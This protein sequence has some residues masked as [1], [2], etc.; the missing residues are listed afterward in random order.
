MRRWLSFTQAVDSPNWTF[1]IVTALLSVFLF[2]VL[3]KAWMRGAFDLTYWPLADGKLTEQFATQPTL[4]NDADNKLLVQQQ[5][6]FYPML[7]HVA[8]L[9]SPVFIP[10]LLVFV[11]YLSLCVMGW[12]SGVYARSLS[13]HALWGVLTPLY[14]GFLISLRSYS[15]EIVEVCLLL[16]TL[17]CLRRSKHIL[18]TVFLSAAVL[19]KE[20]ALL[21]A[22]AAA[23]LYTFELRSRARTIKWFFFSVPL[24]I[25]VVWEGILFTLS[26]R[27]P[28]RIN[29]HEIG[30]PLVGFVRLLSSS[31]H[32]LTGESVFT[33]VPLMGLAS[34]FIVAALQSREMGLSPI[35]KASFWLYGCWL[36]C[37][38]GYVFNPEMT[39]LKAS[40]EFYL[41][42]VTIVLLGKS[43]G[44]VMIGRD[45][46]LLWICYAF[47]LLRPFF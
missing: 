10:G 21:M 9:G 45:V 15:P 6:S 2:G 22:I 28:L 14:P 11:N 4:I 30:L 47:I 34:L 1:L 42:A 3:H 5:R 13:R 39:F 44:Q 31:A 16:G 12:L 19:T 37:L 43:Y 8:S 29:L 18:A 27:L 32:A 46:I 36:F 38:N 33:I 17:L 40:S 26:G 35:E 41:A 25:M 20:T 7:V 24:T 23:G